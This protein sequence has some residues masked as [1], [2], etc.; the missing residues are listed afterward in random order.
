MSILDTLFNRPRITP[1]NPNE[2][3]IILG[4]PQKPQSQPTMSSDAP[5]DLERII[6]GGPGTTGSP[7]RNE[8]DISSLYNP[9]HK[10]MDMM[11]QMIDQR[12][13]R[14]HP[15][16]TRQVLGGVASAFLG[17]EAGNFIDYG[18]YSQDLADWERKLP[19]IE[20]LA[21]QERGANAVDRQFATSVLADRTAQA[22]LDLAT[23]QAAE[24]TR[25]NMA[26]EGNAAARTAVYK[27]KSEHPNHKFDVD[28]QDRII[29]LDPVTGKGQVVTD[30]N[31]Q[32]IYSNDLG[33]A[34]KAALNLKNAKELESVKQ[35]NRSALEEQRQRNRESLLKERE[36]IRKTRLEEDKKLSVG[37]DSTA[38]KLARQQH[39]ADN[40]SHA[41]FWDD[42]SGLPTSA[43]EEDDTGT[44]ESSMD[45]IRRR[46][47]EIKQRA[48]P[49]KSSS[50]TTSTTKST[51]TT[52]AGSGSDMVSV[53]SADGKQKGKV[54][55]KNLSTLPKG[56][57]V[58]GE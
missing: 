18:H 25:H 9:E 3:P 1:Y 2:P 17:P 5:I 24:K 51:T 30:E 46:Y 49:S 58:I 41:L 56:W 33:D 52:N 15:S 12:P 57:K 31:G 6:P 4:G 26:T 47:N 44:Y 28:K 11:S 53:Q 42:Q 36:T 29:A 43:A 23:T 19:P 10:G 21:N 45:D 34:E 13:V 7:A 35:G 37:A 14:P 38:W 32:P 54:P 39:I 8:L 22:K 50:T 40:P 20:H 16:A 55:R 48:T 27:Y